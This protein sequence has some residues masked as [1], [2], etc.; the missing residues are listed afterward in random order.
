MEAL[1]RQLQH[2]KDLCA[3]RRLGVGRPDRHHGTRRNTLRAMVESPCHGGGLS[4]SPFV[5]GAWPTLASEYFLPP[6][7]YNNR[8]RTR[9]SG[10]WNYQNRPSQALQTRRITVRA[11]CSRRGGRS[12][13]AL[14]SP[15]PPSPAS[16]MF[17]SSW[18]TS[19]P[20]WERRSWCPLRASKP[21]PPAARRRSHSRDATLPLDRRRPS[22]PRGP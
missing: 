1:N 2:L 7:E 5:L 11:P 13:S 4:E 8:N 9:G 19:P 21:R 3:C 12:S 18:T 22:R 14:A 15:S 17:T 10:A 6:L 20:R 16:N